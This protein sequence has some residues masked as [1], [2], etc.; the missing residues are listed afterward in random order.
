MAYIDPHADV[1]VPAVLSTTLGLPFVARLAVAFVLLAP[2]GVLAGMP[3]PLGLRS[4]AGRAPALVPWAWGVNG[5]F[6]VI[7]T[8]SSLILAMTFGFTAALLVGTGCYAV[9][10]LVSP[11]GADGRV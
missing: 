8:V 11:R 6:T 7:G 5:F 1:R 2:L 9:A 3:F 4:L 10:A